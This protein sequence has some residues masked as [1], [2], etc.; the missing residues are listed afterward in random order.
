MEK[1]QLCPDRPGSQTIEPKALPDTNASLTVV[2]IIR[3][4]KSEIK[5]MYWLDDDMYLENSNS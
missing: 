4:W 1:L 3:L 5:Q 2:N